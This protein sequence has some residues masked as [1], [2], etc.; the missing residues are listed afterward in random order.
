MTDLTPRP[1][2]FALEGLHSGPHYTQ[3]LTSL[4]KHLRPRTYLEIG[5]STGQ[6]LSLARC[7]SIAIDPHFT[8]TQDVLSGKPACYFFQSS[9]DEFF[10]DH[11][12]LSILGRPIDLAFLDGMHLFQ[13][14]LRDFVN[15][16]RCCRANSV[17]ALHDCM[18]TDAYVARRDVNDKS[19]AAHRISPE[20][21]W[22]GDVWKAVA[23][24]K[25]YRPDL[26]IH[27]YSAPPTGL[28]L[29]TNLDPTSRVLISDYA[30]A[31]DSV[32]TAADYEAYIAQ[33]APE[34]STFFERF[35]NVAQRYWL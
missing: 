3:V 30:E 2:W 1:D 5:T 26:R 18:P 27:G 19:L 23:I 21:W 33:L 11:D 29:V 35:E 6:S 15:T 7:A 14:L 24:L 10:N 9:S 28:V 16:E 20:N 34:A 8:I 22:A 13:F 17:I 4:H 12:P 32:R 25:R 31:V